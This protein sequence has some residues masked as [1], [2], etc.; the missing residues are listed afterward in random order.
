MSRP[1]IHVVFK[2]ILVYHLPV[3]EHDGD[4]C[5]RE[6]QVCEDGICVC[7]QGFTRHKNDIFDETCYRKF[8][9]DNNFIYITQ[10]ISL[11]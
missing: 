4:D 6:T 7:R 2:I 3:C 11:E 1:P 10:I 8:M 5:D 9:Q